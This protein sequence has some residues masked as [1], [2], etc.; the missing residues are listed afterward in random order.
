MNA[1]CF[2]CEVFKFHKINNS[3]RRKKIRNTRPPFL[4]TIWSIHVYECTVPHVFDPYRR[5]RR[6]RKRTNYERTR[7]RPSSSVTGRRGR[8]LRIQK[9]LVKKKKIRTWNSFTHQRRGKKLL[10]CPEECAARTGRFFFSAVLLPF[11]NVL[12]VETD[13]RT[14]DLSVRGGGERLWSTMPRYLLYG[15]VTNAN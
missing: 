7:A 1:S 10:A 5:R 13:E 15:R 3:P 4:M 11:S 12:P 2:H 9:R 6:C 14:T 8:R